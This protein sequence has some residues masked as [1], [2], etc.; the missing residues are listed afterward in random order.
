MTY[1]FGIYVSKPS[2]LCELTP[3]NK[4]PSSGLCVKCLLVVSYVKIRHVE[5]EN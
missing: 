2:S 5:I 4:A 1:I 3:R